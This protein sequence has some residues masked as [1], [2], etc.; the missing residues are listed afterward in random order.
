[1]IVFAAVEA[2]DILEVIW[3]SVIASVFVTTTYS[4]VVLGT[5][6]SAEARRNGEGTGAFVWGGVALLALLLFAA[7]VV[8]GVHT[9]L[10]KG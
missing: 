10:S 1:V 2:G 9:M 3:I 6:R 7:A 8:F 4:F 5:A